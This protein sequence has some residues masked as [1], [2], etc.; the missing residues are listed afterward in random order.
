MSPSEQASLAE[1]LPPAY[2]LRQ[3]N[4]PLD[5]DLLARAER[6]GLSLAVLALA[7]EGEPA[8]LAS[9]S[10]PVWLF[11]MAHRDSAL[12]LS[13]VVPRLEAMSL[14]VLS[15]TAYAL[16]PQAGEADLWLHHFTVSPQGVEALPLSEALAAILEAAFVAA[17]TGQADS[18]RFTRLVLHGFDWRSLLLFRALAAYAK[19]A[20]LNAETDD[21]AEA[22]WRHPALAKRWY[23]LFERRFH[24]Q[25]TADASAFAAEMTEFYAA[26]QAVPRAQD[27]RVWRCYAQLLEALVRTNFYQ[28]D[29]SSYQSDAPAYQGGDARCDFLG[30]GQPVGT[31]PAALKSAPNPR[32]CNEVLVLKWAAERIAGL[33]EPR[34]QFEILVFS[35]QM[36]GVHLRT[37]RIARGGIRWSDRLNDYRTE[38]LG[39]VKAQTVKNA[40]IVPTGAKGGFVIKQPALPASSAVQMPALAAADAYRWFIRG[41]LTITDNREGDQVR[42]PPGLR[43]WD[44]PDPYLVV[45]ADKGTARFSDIANSLAQAVGHWLGD[46]FASGGSQGYDHKKM[47][48]TARGAWV[49]LERHCRERGLNPSSQALRVLGIGDMAGDVFGNGL[50]LARACKLVAAFN[51]QHIFIDPDPDVAISFAERSR[52]FAL[53]TSSWQDYDERLISPGGGVFSRQQKRIVLSPQVQ[54]L[55]GVAETHLSPEALI[56]ALLTLPVDI[57]WNGGIGTYVKGEGESDAEVGDK[58]NDLLRVTGNALR[59]KLFI[60]GGNLGMTQAGRVAFALAGGACNADFIDNAGGVNSSDREVNLKILLKIAENRGDLTDRVRLD[61]LVRYTDEIAAGVLADADAQ[62][63]YLGRAEEDARHRAAEYRRLLGFLEQRAGLDRAREGLPTD[64]ALQARYASGQFLTRP[65][66]AV[67]QS[68]AKLYCKKQLMSLPL[69]QDPALQPFAQAAFPPSALADWGHLLPEHPLLNH[70]IATQLAN[71]FVQELGM[72]AIARFGG[73]EAGLGSQ[74]VWQNV[75][76]GFVCLREAY[77]LP[78]FAREAVTWYGHFPES[79]LYELQNRLGSRVRQGLRWWLR[80]A[81]EAQLPAAADLA[82]AFRTL[83]SLATSTLPSDLGQQVLQAAAGWEAKGLSPHWALRFAF[84][85]TLFAGLGVVWL[86]ERAEVDLAQALHTYYGFYQQWGLDQLAQQLV[87]LRVQTPWQALAREQLQDRLE[88]LLHQ[89]ACAWLRCRAR[90]LS[91]PS[92][93]APLTDESP[94]EESDQLAYLAVMLDRLHLQVAQF[95]QQLREQSPRPT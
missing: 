40:L 86:A 35:P 6:D 31:A 69:A 78:A 32:L 65:E 37:S 84:P 81:A 50:L 95:E 24:P 38:I 39:L 11:A 7:G 28:S 77:E 74:A 61:C 23:R 12:A 60:E 59:C 48:I 9:P 27:D 85:D 13:D 75:M 33:P 67:M 68:Y 89:A 54:M 10:S 63:A 3:V 82:S 53:P 29:D 83:A 26:L 36:E 34:P 17:W 19:Q 79:L 91:L 57:V 71:A 5:I 22:L 70:L 72:S 76:R 73:A 62:T 58:A 15:E 44:E 52:L 64:A 2:H 14:R 16:A 94:P 30:G 56:R 47:G 87:S 90:P 88:A 42:T 43:V 18:D 80:R 55:L 93:A 41:L 21:M 1:R 46:A 8:A 51:H 20:R 66:L 49:A 45:A 25:S 4:N 92:L